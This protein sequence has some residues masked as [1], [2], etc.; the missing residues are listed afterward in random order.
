MKN[1]RKTHI[2][3]QRMYISHLKVLNTITLVS[4]VSHKTTKWVFSA[5]KS[6]GILVF[7][8]MENLEMSGNFISMKS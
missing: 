4:F 8:V 5:E 7:F 1:Y 3:P 6:Q 2:C